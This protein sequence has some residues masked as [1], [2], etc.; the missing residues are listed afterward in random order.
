[1]F[2]LILMFIAVLMT[3]DLVTAATIPQAQVIQLMNASRQADISEYYVRTG[4]VLQDMPDI[5]QRFACVRQYI[6]SKMDP[7]M[8]Y[9][10]WHYPV[11][12]VDRLACL[13]NS[14]TKRM[15]QG[16]R[17]LEAGLTTK[18]KKEIGD[19]IAFYVDY[20]RFIKWN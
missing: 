12:I 4:V 17:D 15:M 11:S 13:P 8:Q 1:M 20:E 10:Y 19:N 18:G 3:I 7:S 6:W 14:H 16:V 5:D 9:G 2:K